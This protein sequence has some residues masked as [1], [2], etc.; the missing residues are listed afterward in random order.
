MKHRKKKLMT[1]DKV[2]HMNED[3]YRQ[4][5]SRKEG[6]GLASMEDCVDATTQGLKEFRENSKEK[7]QLPVI[8]IN[9]L[10]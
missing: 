8:A 1:M 2:L 6:R 9:G 3:I 5:V 4:Y 10:V 7:L